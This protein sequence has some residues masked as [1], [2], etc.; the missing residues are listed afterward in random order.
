MEGDDPL[1]I[2]TGQATVSVSENVTAD[3]TINL[4][5]SNEDRLYPFPSSS[6]I[7]PNG[8]NS[9]SFSFNILGNDVQ[10]GDATV[11]VFGQADDYTTGSDS[12]LVKDDD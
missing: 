5:S 3:L 12:I 8:S 1:N 4:T 10:D 6:V 11:V 2:I 9:A 7:I